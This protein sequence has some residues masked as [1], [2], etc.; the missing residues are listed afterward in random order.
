MK[1]LLL[2]LI[3][4][5]L[6]SNICIAQKVDNKVEP[7][8]LNM[9]NKWALTFEQG[10]W[11]IHDEKNQTQ[12]QWGPYTEIGKLRDGRMLIRQDKR[13]GYVD[14][15]G[16]IIIPCQYDRAQPFIDGSAIVSIDHQWHKI[17]P[18]GKIFSSYSPLFFVE[19]SVEMFSKH[20]LEL[21]SRWTSKPVLTKGEQGPLSLRINMGIGKESKREL[22]GLR[23]KNGQLIVPIEYDYIV[24]KPNGF[25]TL[26]QGDKTGLI[27]CF[28]KMVF[29]LNYQ[30]IFVTPSGLVLLESKG[31]SGLGDTTGT[32]IIPCKYTSMSIIGHDRFAVSNG[33]LKGVINSADEVIVPIKYNI[34]QGYS[35]N[36]I[37]VGRYKAIAFGGQPFVNWGWVDEKGEIVIPLEIDDA[38]DFYQGVAPAMLNRL[39]WGLLGKDGKWVLEPKLQK[40]EPFQEGLAAAKSNDKWGY[41]DTQGKWV[42][43]PQFEGLKNFNGYY[44]PFKSEGKWGLMDKAGKMVLAPKFTSINAT[45]FFGFDAYLHNNT[46]IELDKNGQ[47]V[48]EQ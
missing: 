33:N 43:E 19:D 3:L 45:P 9:N 7:I 18:N 39:G 11:H 34:I 17:D 40:L 12:G 21:V 46:K 5:F 15:L 24:S 27:N 47:V 2:T 13:Y 8:Y 10:K 29:P 20:G 22:F 38:H 41:I 4:L 25:F 31:K 14:S 37:K 32:I 36:L 30:D 23:D 1:N 26:H 42:I 16:E 48:F 28:G 6:F 44:A 35:E